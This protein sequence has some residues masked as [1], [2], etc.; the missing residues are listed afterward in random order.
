MHSVYYPVFL[1]V[2]DLIY[3]LCDSGGVQIK[4]R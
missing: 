2:V 1:G 4:H 3:V